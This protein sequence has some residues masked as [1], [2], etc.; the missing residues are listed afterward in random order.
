[1]VYFVVLFASFCDL[2]VHT[3]SVPLLVISGGDCFCFYLVLGCICVGVL[4]VVAGFRLLIVFCLQ[5]RRCVLL[6]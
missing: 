2:V 1:M 3:G 6:F 4:L 5:M